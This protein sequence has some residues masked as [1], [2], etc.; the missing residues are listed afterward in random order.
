LQPST[1]YWI[2][3]VD[4]HTGF[5]AGWEAATSAAGTGVSGESHAFWTGAAWSNELDS[6]FNGT[7]PEM[8]VDVNATAPEPA[9]LWLFL[10]ALV[11]FGGVQY[12]RLA[13]KSGMAP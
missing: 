13:P 11:V 5:F 9:T 4:N 7:I 1:Q 10:A 6:T 3:L 8:Q 12:A 2:V